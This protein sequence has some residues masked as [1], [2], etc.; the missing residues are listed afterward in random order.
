MNIRAKQR[1]DSR[2]RIVEAA[3]STFSEFGFLGGSTR[4]I[5][6]RAGLNQG[7]VTYHFPTKDA[8]WRAAVDHIFARVRAV[9][10]ERIERKAIEDPRELSRALIRD[11]VRVA[12]AN[13]ELIR[14]MVEEGKHPDERMVWLVETHIRPLYE[15]F[16]AYGAMPK[17]DPAL[18]PHAFYAL[19]GAASLI[20]AV[21]PECRQLTG[22]DPGAAAAIE[23][24]AEFVA[25]MLLPKHR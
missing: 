22:L 25:N 15:M 1:S 6:A 10:A 11:F 14:L 7:L 8:L 9:Q 4:E 12:A 5:A 17:L 20:F 18:A 24:H 2:L 13:P 3:I 19:V 21:S 16:Q 23:T